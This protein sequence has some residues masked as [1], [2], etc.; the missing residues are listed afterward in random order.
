MQTNVAKTDLTQSLIDRAR[1]LLPALRERAQSL[2]R[3]L[4]GP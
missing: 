1:A 2:R 3:N 4:Q